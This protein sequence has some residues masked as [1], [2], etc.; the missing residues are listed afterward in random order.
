MTIEDVGG[1]HFL[2]MAKSAK[3]RAMPD[4]DAHYV[5]AIAPNAARS[6][7]RDLSSQFVRTE[8]RAKDT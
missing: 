8:W 7:L 3:I 6:V 4:E 5:Y 1:R 2:K